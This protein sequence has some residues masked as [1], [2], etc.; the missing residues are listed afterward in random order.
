MQNRFHRWSRR[1]GASH[2]GGE[3]VH[4]LRI[5]QRLDLC[6]LQQMLHPD[7]GESLR[8][9]RLQVPAAA[10]DVENLLFLAEEIAF[11]DLDGSISAAMQHERGVPS[12][13]PGG[14]NPLL[15]IGLCIYPPRSG[16]KDS[17]LRLGGL[18][19]CRF[20]FQSKKPE[21]R[22]CPGP[23]WRMKNPER[24]EKMERR[25]KKELMLLRDFAYPHI[26]SVNHQPSTR[27]NLHDHIQN[28]SIPLHRGSRSRLLHGRARAGHPNL[29]LR[30]R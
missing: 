7:R 23:R 12:Q 28:Y 2:L 4:H 18:N 8:L 30:R 1:A 9:D 21:R 16:P 19:R 3:L 20:N 11:P 24:T 15:Q 13:Q 26:S 10:F 27:N 22:R 25:K 14:I 29:G 5:R 6:E 17:S